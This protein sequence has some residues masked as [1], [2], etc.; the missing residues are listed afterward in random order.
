MTKENRVLFTGLAVAF[1][2]PLV[3]GWLLGWPAWVTVPLLVMVLV[4]IYRKL[5]YGTRTVADQVGALLDKLGLHQENAVRDMTANRLAKLIEASGN[6]EAAAEVRSRFDSPRPH[7]AGG[8]RRT[9]HDV[10]SK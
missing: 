4:G 3:L 6:T 7:G 1:V 2:L 9:A 10:F 8:L 5:V